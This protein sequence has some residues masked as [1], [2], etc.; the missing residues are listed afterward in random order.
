MVQTKAKGISS[1]SLHI[2]AMALMLETISGPRCFPP[3]SG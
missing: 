1:F 2:L 3:R